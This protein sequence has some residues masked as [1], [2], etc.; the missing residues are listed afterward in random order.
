MKYKIIMNHHHGSSHPGLVPQSDGRRII[1]PLRQFQG[2]Y[3]TD[4]FIPSLVDNRCSYDEI[5]YFLN[6]IS[7]T[8]RRMKSIRAS[9]LLIVLS[10]VA[11]LFCFI[12]G[13]MLE[14]E[15]T[16]VDFYKEDYNDSGVFLIFFGMFI[17]IAVNIAAC[18]YRS[19]QKNKLFKQVVSVLERHK[20]L[21]LQ[22]GLRWAVPENCNWLELW[23][24]YIFFPY[25]LQPYPSPSLALNIPSYQ[26][27][28]L[29]NYI[30]NN[31]HPHQQS[32]NIN[33]SKT[34]PFI[35]NEEVIQG[36]PVGENQSNALNQNID[37]NVLNP[38]SRAQIPFAKGNGQMYQM[39]E[40]PIG[41][42]ANVM[43][44]G[45]PYVFYQMPALNANTMG[46][47]SPNQDNTRLLR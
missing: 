39:Q 7:F 11:F 40:T 5:N 44:S 41:N 28:Q 2:T 32:D 10:L 24:D 23:M 43:Q 25:Y 13:F 35:N 16:D 36:Y 18:I 37:I 42:P 26:Q 3:K 8:T 9:N 30:N 21:F 46:Y 38:N 17:I 1:F 22:R 14:I 4:H 33:R 27:P 47:W 31:T 34:L 12:F 6:D 45:Y 15:N 29:C 20:Q 19:T